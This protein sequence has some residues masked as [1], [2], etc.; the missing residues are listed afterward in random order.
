MAWENMPVL[1][2][3]LDP[4]SGKF[5]VTGKF[6]RENGHDFEDVSGSRFAL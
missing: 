4:P 3:H 1:Q 6:Q 2:T 5:S